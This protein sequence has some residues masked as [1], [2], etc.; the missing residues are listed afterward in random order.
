MTTH[1]AVRIITFLTNS[2]LNRHTL[3][4]AV[5][6]FAT[7]APT[8]N[9]THKKLLVQKMIFTSL[10]I[11]IRN[12]FFLTSVFIRC[13]RASSSSLEFS[14][15]AEDIPSDLLSWLSDEAEPT[16]HQRPCEWKSI[17]NEYYCWLR[18]VTWSFVYLKKSYCFDLVRNTNYR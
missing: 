16:I 17:T 8:F 1:R 7:V 10:V 3:H 15:W 12:T 9:L 11:I 18:I 13:F 5:V 2:S 14:I 6:T 4:F